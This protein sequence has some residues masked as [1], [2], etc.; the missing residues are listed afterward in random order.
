MGD[1]IALKA[2]ETKIAIRPPI[3]SDKKALSSLHFL[4]H[5]EDESYRSTTVMLFGVYQGLAS[6]SC[7][8]RKLRGRL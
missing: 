2:L 5:L 7:M 6:D 4:P 8:L 1:H 3:L